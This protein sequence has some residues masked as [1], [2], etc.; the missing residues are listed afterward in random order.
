MKR[1]ILA[2]VVALGLLFPSVSAFAAVYVHGYTK[3]N[4]TY[5]NGYYRSSPDG[6]PYNNYSFPGNTNPYTGVTAGGSV[7]SYLNNYYGGSS[8]GSTYYTPSSY[9]SYPSVY[10]P[11]CPANSSYDGISSCKC[12]YGYLNSGGSCVSQY[13]Y[14][15]NLIGYSSTYDSLSG[16]CKCYAGYV[17]N[18]SGQCTSATL[19]CSQQIGLMS[20]YN[21]STKKC[22]CMAGYVFDGTSCVYKQPTYY[23]PP[24]STT[25]TNNCPIHSHTSPTDSTKCQCDTGFQAN[26]ALTACV[27]TAVSSDTTSNNQ[28]CSNAYGTFSYWNGT[29]GANG[30][31]NCTCQVGYNWNSTNTACVAYTYTPPPLDAKTQGENYFKTNKTCGGLSGDPYSYCMTYALN[32]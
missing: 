10:T 32:H 14:C 3:S 5:V 24:S 19:V 6:N 7:T 12:N 4:G 31:L 22:E 30:S 11:S 1:I 20:Q 13:T 16:T 27:V 17:L 26:S 8:Y 23:S 25:V 15:D 28:V 9:T 21:S 18:S 2:A 29:K